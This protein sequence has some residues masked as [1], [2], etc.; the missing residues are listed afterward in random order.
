MNISKNEFLFLPLGGVGRIGMNVSLYHCQSKWIMIDLGIGFADETTPG[1]E[2]LIADVSFIAQRKKDLLGIIIT[3]AHEDHCGAIPYLWEELQCPIYATN[4][5]ANFLKE[6]LK[7]FQLES[8]VPV[9]EVNTNSSLNL[10][11]F[12]VEFINVTHSIPEAH[13]ILISTDIGSV[14]HTG[15]WKFDHKPVVGLTSNINRLREI[16]DKGDL[17]AVICDSTNILSKCNPKSEGEIYDNIY[18]IIR[19]SKKLVA[20][21]LF[22]SNVARIETISQAAKALDRKV[23]LLGRSL[24]RIVKVAQDSGYLID[25]AHFF[26]AKDA[27]DLPREKLLLICTGCQGEPMAATSK[28]AHKRHYAFKIQ[29][30]DTIILSSR[31]IPGN[32]TRVHNMLNAFVEMGVEVITEKT[33]HIHSSGHPTKS[34]LREMYSL[35]KPKM[36][37]PVHGE[38]IHTHAHVKF[39][40]ECGVKK[41]IMITPGDI[42]NLENG[43]KID[44]IDVNYFCIDGTLLRYPEGSVI[45]MR[46]RMR[47]AGAIVVTAVVNKKNKLLVKPKVFTPGAFEAKEDAAIIQRITKAVE[48]AF[49]SRSTR[50]IRNKI[51]SS[52]FSILNEYLLKKPIIKVQIEQV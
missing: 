27:A 22:A 13:S 39:A 30:G 51:E 24:W 19:Q 12:T 21:S 8:M 15:D 35:I 9:R 6:K 25:S 34:E 31:I 47:D 32:E 23:V 1:I 14:L 7:E 36:S 33:E 38:Y 43:E 20:V 10:G 37:I 49:S 28:L 29:R 52:I 44:A 17:L 26:E 45:K 11:P 40:K 48:S 50:K 18:R 5:T 41:A 3:H 46:K 42:V 2:L 4:F 16:G